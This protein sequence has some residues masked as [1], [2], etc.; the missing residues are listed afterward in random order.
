MKLARDFAFS[1]D[2]CFRQIF[3]EF[4]LDDV[5]GSCFFLSYIKV[6]RLPPT[7]GITIINQQ[8]FLKHKRLTNF[9]NLTSRAQPDYEL[10]SFL[11]S[12]KA[13]Y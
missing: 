9:S 10:F 1:D 12:F 4:V 7:L 11:D 5:I 3:F 2:K 13:A 8:P 6:T